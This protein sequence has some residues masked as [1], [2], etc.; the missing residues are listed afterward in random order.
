[1]QDKTQK[2]KVERTIG[3]GQ[4][5]GCAV[6]KVRSGDELSGD[7]EHRLLDID[8]RH[9]EPQA[10]EDFG[11]DAAACPDIEDR[12]DAVPMKAEGGD[13]IRFEKSQAFRSAEPLNVPINPA[14]A[15]L[16]GPGAASVQRQPP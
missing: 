8:A 15:H 3:E 1:M 4:I 9:V 16:T 2:T 5:F 13:P 12:P 10:R 7:F 14:S 11:K 6:L